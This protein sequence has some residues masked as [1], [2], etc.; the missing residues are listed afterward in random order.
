LEDDRRSVSV[1]CGFATSVTILALEKLRLK[2][3]GRVPAN[4][5]G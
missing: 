1:W 2:L 5:A 4:S 3:E